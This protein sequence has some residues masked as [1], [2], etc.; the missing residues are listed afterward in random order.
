MGQV[1]MALL[2]GALF[3]GGLTVS[4]MINPAK[5][6]SFLDIAGDWDPSLI[7]VMAGAVGITA[8]GYRLTFGRAQPI[9]SDR[10]SLP[11]AADI[12]ARL[13]TGAAIFGIGWGLGGYCPGPALAGLFQGAP[14]TLT[15]L[16]TM[17]VGLVAGRLATEATT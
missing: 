10:F 8:I 2:C 3:G 15:F 9:F 17:C 12:D 4:G 1:I 16:A 6:V 7:L 14:E 13:L 5:I 11:T